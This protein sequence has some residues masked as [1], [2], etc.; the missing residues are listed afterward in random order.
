MEMPHTQYTAQ[1]IARRGEEIYERDFKE[2]LEPAHT[3]K[4]LVID[5]DTGDHEMDT[6]E[7]AAFQRAMARNPDGN[8]YLKRIGFPVAHHLGGWLRVGQP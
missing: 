1:E 3:G 5:I 7:V 2:K 8:R 4:F 6:D